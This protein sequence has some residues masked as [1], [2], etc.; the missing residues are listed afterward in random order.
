M[1]PTLPA[2]AHRYAP[3]FTTASVR[4]RSPAF[5]SVCPRAPTG[6][7]RWVP[8]GGAVGND[9][10]SP[11]FPVVPL[12]AQREKSARARTCML[13]NGGARTRTRPAQQRSRRRKN[14][15]TSWT[16]CFAKARASREHW[17]TGSPVARQPTARGRAQV[18]TPRSSLTPP[19]G[20][21]SAGNSSATWGDACDLLASCDAV[22]AS[23]RQGEI[24]RI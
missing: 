21:R 19:S 23:F 12:C 14:V 7:C 13:A 8:V 5:T 22:V 11:A 16:I 3:V 2:P 24:S 10:K 1:N 20:T 18:G 6:T 17:R 4:L 15:R 9:R